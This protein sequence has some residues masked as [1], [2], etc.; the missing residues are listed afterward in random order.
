M[1]IIIQDIGTT[2]D[3]LWG[4]RLGILGIVMFSKRFMSTFLTEQ[5]ALHCTNTT[6]TILSQ[7]LDL[8][9]I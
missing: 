3:S 8:Q 5:A 7:K 6:G 4:G 1:D 2:A 9:E